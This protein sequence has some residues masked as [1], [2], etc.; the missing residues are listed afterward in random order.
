M[1]EIG[2]QALRFGGRGHARE[3]ERE[4]VGEPWLVAT[5]RFAMD[6]RG[7][8]LRGFEE[9]GIVEKIERLER[10]VRALAAGATSTGVRQVKGDELGEVR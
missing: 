6:T 8:R 4:G 3:H 7:K 5:A 2:E 1:L 10:R 9:D